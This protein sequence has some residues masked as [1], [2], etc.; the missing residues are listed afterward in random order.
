MIVD[1]M[2]NV[3]AAAMAMLNGN[4]DNTR[5]DTISMSSGIQSEKVQVLTE[6]LAG[7]HLREETQYKH[8][9]LDLLRAQGFSTRHVFQAPGAQISYLFQL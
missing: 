4:A 3:T 2:K 5:L 8:S 6:D 9:I 1:T 7:V